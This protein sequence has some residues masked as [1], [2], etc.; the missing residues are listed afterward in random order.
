MSMRTIVEFN[1][2]L[3]REID[4]D[5]EGFVRAVRRMLN[6]GVNDRMNDTRQELERFGVTTTPTHHHSNAATVILYHARGGPEF[7]RHE[8]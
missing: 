1:H 3:T 6:A 8:L 7:Y 2:D 4:A 5:P